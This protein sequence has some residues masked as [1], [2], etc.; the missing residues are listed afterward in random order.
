M[1]QR[2]TLVSFFQGGNRG[3]VRDRLPR[4][5][6]LKARTGPRL[7]DGGVWTM[8]LHSSSHYFSSQA[9]IS[10][11]PRAGAEAREFFLTA[12]PPNLPFPAPS[13]RG[14]TAACSSLACPGPLSTT[15]QATL[16]P[17]PPLSPTS[18]H[19]GNG[20]SLPHGS[21]CTGAPLRSVLH[22]EARTLLQK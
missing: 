11:S 5:R 21:C 1:N 4:W 15:L 2:I 7:G 20:S 16:S 10:E 9:L 12:P 8:R 17:P 14:I 6:V 13:L 3:I 22:T 18:P 19:P